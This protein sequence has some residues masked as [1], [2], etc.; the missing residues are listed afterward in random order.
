MDCLFLYKKLPC[1]LV[2]SVNACHF[3][4]LRSFSLSGI[5][6][7]A[8][9][10]SRD[11]ASKSY[12][13]QL[14]PQSLN[15]SSNFFLRASLASVLVVMPPGRLM[16]SR[17]WNHS[18]KLDFSLLGI[19]MGVISLKVCKMTPGVSFGLQRVKEGDTLCLT[20]NLI[21]TVTMWC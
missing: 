18:Q 15:K 13:L 4:Q 3:N 8:E 9:R 7:Y 5:P 16:T 12:Q 6:V 2:H 11:T 20:E 10:G 14:V 17:I 1:F 19:L 21:L